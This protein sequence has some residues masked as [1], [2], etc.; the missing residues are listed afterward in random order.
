MDENIDELKI[1]LIWP[2]LTVLERVICNKVLHIN[3]WKE[4]ITKYLHV[5]F[6]SF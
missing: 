4:N 3:I 2:S 5:I 1:Y 6:L